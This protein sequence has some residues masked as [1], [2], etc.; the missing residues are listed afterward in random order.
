MVFSEGKMAS[1]ISGP[2]IASSGTAHGFQ[3]KSLALSS[4]R[5]S[6]E[7]RAVG[8]RKAAVALFQEL[9]TSRNFVL[10]KDLGG[11]SPNSSSDA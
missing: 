9:T 2:T 5:P 10:G 7:N 8:G 1:A 11:Q 4:C 6:K 3:Q